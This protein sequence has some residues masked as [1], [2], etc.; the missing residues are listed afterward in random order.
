MI[1]QNLT[2]S[3]EEQYLHLQH[4]QRHQP[5][6]LHPLPHPENFPE[7]SFL[8]TEPSRSPLNRTKMFN[9]RLSSSNFSP[10]VR[11]TSSQISPGWEGGGSRSPQEV[12]FQ[13]QELPV[14]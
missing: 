5:K 14:L 12:R 2:P 13:D 11:E 9:Q 8:A 3:L 7:E 1:L 4:Q 6:L 10:P